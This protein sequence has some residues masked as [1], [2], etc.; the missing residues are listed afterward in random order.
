M[1]RLGGKIAGL[2]NEHHTWYIMA[3]LW[4]GTFSLQNLPEKFHLSFQQTTTYSTYVWLFEMFDLPGIKCLK[5]ASDI[6]GSNKYIS[7]LSQYSIMQILEFN[8][9]TQTFQN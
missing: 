3:R 8:Y 7:I 6:L 4:D 1:F 9:K 5:N 2:N